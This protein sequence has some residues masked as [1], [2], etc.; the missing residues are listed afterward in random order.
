M[1]GKGAAKPSVS[2]LTE[3]QREALFTIVERCEGAEMTEY[4]RSVAGV[5]RVT[6]DELCK[7]G[8]VRFLSSKCT[9][10]A[11][12]SGRETLRAISA[13]ERGAS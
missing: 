1:S 3:A 8:H 11:T 13:A 4:S 7:L 2:S 5:K 6:L 10:V 9:W 12:A